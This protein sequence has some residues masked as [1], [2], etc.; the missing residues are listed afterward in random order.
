MTPA[1]RLDERLAVCLQVHFLGGYA[2]V[3]LQ[4]GVRTAA[5]AAQL[6]ESDLQRMDFKP[7][8]I[9]KFVRAVQTLVDGD[10]GMCDLRVCL[11]RASVGVF[12]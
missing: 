9:K 6:T 1:A 11:L 2:D 3:L 4:S 10:G 8:H 7:F 5:Q 12:V